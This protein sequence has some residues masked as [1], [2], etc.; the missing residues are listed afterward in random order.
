MGKIPTNLPI[1]EVKSPDPVTRGMT[2]VIVLVLFGALSEITFPSQ[3]V[4]PVE[5]SME[6]LLGP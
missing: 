2:L 5:L 1:R 4:V 3:L 6:T